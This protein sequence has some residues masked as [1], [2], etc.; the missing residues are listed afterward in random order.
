[1]V[2]SQH[3]FFVMILE[4]AMP[5]S[6]LERWRAWMFT[7][8]GLGYISSQSL[9]WYEINVLGAP[10]RYLFLGD[11][12]LFIGFFGSMVGLL[13][14]YPQV[15]DRSPRATAAIAWFLLAGV[16]AAIIERGAVFLLSLATGTPYADTVTGVEPLFLVIYLSV[17][18]GFL[19]FGVIGI[20]SRV[21]SRAVGILFLAPIATLVLH[22]VLPRVPG[23]PDPI[24]VLFAS[25]GVA[26]LGVGYLLW[27]GISR[28][29]ASN[30][31]AS[32]R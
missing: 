29:P 21:P 26:M 30:S 16:A 9:S 18:F 17:L 2:G 19:V 8:A 32:S 22:I 28:R 31:E 1:M 14:L 5:W 3:R 23:L 13:G 6:R 20:H 7:F 15:A 11:H 4:N 25:Y 12:L 24:H 27:N 10:D